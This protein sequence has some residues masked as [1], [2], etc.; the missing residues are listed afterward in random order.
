MDGRIA[1]ITRT[2]QIVSFGITFAGNVGELLESGSV[3]KNESRRPRRGSTK[4]AP[5]LCGCRLAGTKPE[6]ADQQRES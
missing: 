1:Q 5:G 3:L 6:F 2:A 4:G